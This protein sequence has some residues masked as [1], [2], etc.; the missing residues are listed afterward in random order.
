MK[1]GSFFIF[2]AGKLF[3]EGLTLVPELAIC[4]TFVALAVALGFALVHV[5]NVELI[6][7]VVFV[8]GITMGSRRGMLIGGISMGLFTIFNPLGAPMPPIAFAQVVSMAAIGC[9]G[10]MIS[11]RKGLKPVWARMALLGLACT[12]L[13]DLI[14]NA[15]V[16]LSLGLI[17]RWTSVLAA[18]MAFSLLHMASNLVI[19]AVAG[20]VL[21]KMGVLHGLNRSP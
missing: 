4:A 19:F 5:P 6:T 13:Y 7:L 8:S 14:T 3:Y 18:G 17:N 10:G 20:P 11:H 16:A 15:A 21:A 9:I 1:V 2:P 12:F